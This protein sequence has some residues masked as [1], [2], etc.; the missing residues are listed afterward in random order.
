MTNGNATQTV[1]ERLHEKLHAV[2]DNDRKKMF[3]FLKMATGET[4]RSTKVVLEMDDDEARQVLSLLS[5]FVKELN[6]AEEYGEVKCKM[7][8]HF[9]W[10]ASREELR[11][12]LLMRHGKGSGAISRK[13]KVSIDW[14]YKLQY[15]MLAKGANLGKFSHI[16]EM[17]A[18]YIK[19]DDIHDA[20]ALSY[21][22]NLDLFAAKFL[23]TKKSFSLRQ[24][25]H[26]AAYY[27]REMLAKIM[28]GGDIRP[29]EL[30]I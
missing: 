15:D 28:F 26:M 5:F 29:A 27:A 25:Q 4:A 8:R 19:E 16:E 13:L 20:L 1:Q 22:K 11:I 12:L 23:F 2:F 24:G 9:L 10:K 7:H 6:D 30:A 18:S 21:D 14:V 17:I 3:P